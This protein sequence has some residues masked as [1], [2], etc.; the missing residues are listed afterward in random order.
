MQHSVLPTAARNMHAVLL[1]SFGIM[2]AA[3]LLLFAGA[4]DATGTVL[5]HNVTELQAISTDPAGSYLLANDI[6]ASDTVNWAAYP[7]N[8]F[9]PIAS[10]SG[11][12]D[13]GG[14]TI[15]GLYQMSTDDAMFT[16]IATTGNVVNLAFASVNIECSN[17]AAVL[18]NDNKGLIKRCA[19]MSGT[20]SAPTAAGFCV[21][22]NG[23]LVES[24]VN[25]GTDIWG[26]SNA[27]GL[28]ADQYGTVASCSCSGN[29]G[30][31]GLTPPGLVSAGLVFT[32]HSGT[33]QNC[34]VTGTV[35]GAAWAAGFMATAMSG[36][37]VSNCFVAATLSA[38]SKYGFVLT[39]HADGATVAGCC[40]DTTVTGTSTSGAGTGYTT[41]QM[42]GSDSCYSGWDF[43]NVWW[44]PLSG[45][46]CYP[47][48]K[49][50]SWAF[51][52]PYVARAAT[53][54]EWDGGLP[55]TFDVEFHE[56]M[57]GPLADVTD[58]KTGDQTGQVDFGSSTATH[59][60]YTVAGSGSAYTITVTSADGPGTVVANIVPG[61]CYTTSQ[62][63]GFKNLA[64]YS[65]NN[66]VTI[67]A[68]PS[69]TGIALPSDI[70]NHGRADT[71]DFTVTFDLPVTG[72][73]ASDFSV[74]SSTVTGAT[75]TGVSPTSG[76][77]TT[78]TVTVSTGTG[79]GAVQLDLL[80]DDSLITAQNG[81][82]GGW[83]AG[84]GD[85]SGTAALYYLDK[86]TIPATK[87]LNLPGGYTDWSQLDLTHTTWT[88][89]DALHSTGSVLIVD[90]EGPFTVNWVPVSGASFCQDLDTSPT[91][92][93]TAVQ[94]PTGTCS[95][96]RSLGVD[97][98]VTFDHPVTGVDAT[99]FS[100]ANS[101]VS[102][103]SIVSVL[104]DSGYASLFTVR[105]STGTGTGTV[106]LDVVDDNSIVTDLRV[107][108]G[109]FDVADGN[110]SGAAG[111]YYVYK[112]AVPVGTALS[113][114]GGYQWTD[115]DLD[116]TISRPVGAIQQAASGSSTF[117]VRQ[118]GAFTVTWTP[119]SGSPFCQELKSAVGVQSVHRVS[120]SAVDPS[121]F[122][123]PESEVT[124]R[125]TF[126][127]PVTGVDESDFQPTGDGIPSV[128]S[129]AA[130]DTETYNVTLTNLPMRGLVG[131]D[132]LNDGSILDSEGNPLG[133]PFTGTEQ[134]AVD[135]NVYRIGASLP[136]P[137]ELG[138]QRGQLVLA[139]TTSIP[140]KQVYDG[141]SHPELANTVYNTFFVQSA[142][143]ASPAAAAQDAPS[144]L[145][146][147]DNLAP[148]AH[149]KGYTTIA[150][151]YLDGTEKTFGQ[152]IQVSG[153]PAHPAMGVYQTDL[154]SGGQ[155][156]AYKVALGDPLQPSGFTSYIHHNSQVRPP[157][158]Q[159]PAQPGYEV[160]YLWED[161]EKWLHAYKDTGL[162]VLH[163]EDSSLHFL[164]VQVVDVQL[165]Q[166]NATMAM[167][168]GDE[169]T[170]Q[171]PLDAAFKPSAP[172]AYVSAGKNNL[173][174]YVYQ[175]DI[176]GS[177]QGA[178]FAI[179]KT[180]TA[181][182]AEVFWLRYCEGTS[183]GVTDLHIRWPYE[184]T[185][186]TFDWPDETT[187]RGKFQ[188]YVRGKSP[189][190]TGPDVA[191]KTDTDFAVDVMPYY[192]GA[193]GFASYKV[194]KDPSLNN[195][196]ATNG[197]GWSLLRYQTGTPLGSG[198]YFKAVRSAWHDNAAF[199]PN[200][201]T[202]L[203]GNVGVEITDS[204]NHKPGQ[205]YNTYAQNSGQWQETPGTP[206][207][208]FV[209]SNS[210]ENRYDWKIYDGNDGVDAVTVNPAATGQ[211]IPVNTGDLEVWWYQHDTQADSPSPR[212]G[213]DWPMLPERYAVA[214]PAATNE[215]VIARQDGTGVIPY[216]T[217]EL[218]YQND[219]TRPG[220]NPND[221]HAL[222]ETYGS[223]MAVF[224]L[225]CDLGSGATSL[226]YVLIRHRDA[227][228]NSLWNYDVYSVRAEKTVTSGVE[229]YTFQDW[230]QKGLSAT[231]S[232]SD[233]Y[234]KWAGTVMQPPWPLAAM[235]LCDETTCASGPG[236][237]DRESTYWAKA[238]GDAGGTA[239]VA[240]QF[241]YVNQPDFYWPTGPTPAV[242]AHV[243]WLDGYH[244]VPGTP[245]TVTY[246][247]HWPDDATIPTMKTGDIL[248]KAR[249]GL[250]AM[251]GNVSVR[252]LYQQSTALNP[253]KSSTEVIDFERKRPVPPAAPVIL[254]A[255]PSD[256][257][258][259]EKQGLTYFPKLDPALKPR[260][261]YN[262][263]NSELGFTGFFVEP[264]LGDYYAFLDVM[265]DADKKELL[266][267]SNNTA[268]TTAVNALYAA[269][270]TVVQV[271][272]DATDFE[273]DGLALTTGFATDG[274][275]VTLAFNNAV[276]ARPGP[277]SL[278]IIKVVKDWKP[279]EIAEIP[280]DCP[281]DERLVMMHKGDF[282]G[283]PDQYKF[284]WRTHPDVDG[285]KP[286]WDPNTR[287]VTDADKYNTFTPD[288]T[289]YP[290][291]VGAHEITIEG[292]GLF[293]LSD[294]WFICR[295]T[296]K[297]SGAKSW[298]DDWSDWTEPQLAPG[299]IKRVVGEISPFTQRASGGGI[300]GAET[301]F[302]SFSDNAVN[303]VVSM[304]SQAGPRWDGDVPLNCQNLD[305]F[306]LIQIYETVFG[307][308]RAL[309]VDAGYDYAPANNA[310]LLVAGRCADLYMLL[311]NE[312]YAD[313]ADPT[314]AYGTN[315]AW[316]YASQATSIHCFMNQTGSLMEEELALLRGRDDSQSPPVSTQPVYNRLIW[317]F[318]TDMNGGEVA[319]ALNYN[320]QD[321]SGNADG[322]I[323]ENDAKKL[324]PQGHGDAWG[325]YLSAIKR[326]YKL[327]RHPNYTWVPR[328]EAVMV[329]GVAVTV[330]F[331]DERKFAKAAAARARTGAEIMNLTYRQYYTEDPAGQWQG[332]HDSNTDRAWGVSE[333]GCR[334]GTGAYFDWV[335]GNA[336]LP[337]DDTDPT[338]TGIRKIDR[339]TVADL[340]DIAAAYDQIE[341][342]MKSADSGLN[343]L[344]LAK[345]VTPFDI[346]PTAIDAGETHFEQIYARAMTALTN[347]VSVFNN[348]ANC[349]Q[350]L[351]RQSDTL[352]Q[353]QQTVTDQEADFNNRLIE[354]FGYPYAEDIGPTGTYPT[355]YNGPD[356]YHYDIVDDN[357]LRQDITQDTQAFTVKL[358]ESYVDG[359][360]QVRNPAQVG[361]AFLTTED[362]SHVHEVTFQLSLSNFGIVKPSGWTSRRAPGE[363]QQTRSDLLQGAGNFKKCIREYQDTVGQI[364]DQLTLITDKSA[365]FGAEMFVRTGK[366]ATDT[367]I[368]AYILGLNAV[369]RGLQ[370]TADI[371]DK[372]AD[373]ETE[374]IPKVM[375]LVAGVACGT[376]TDAL[377][378]LRGATQ[379]GA[380]GLEAGALIG[381]DSA[382][383]SAE[384]AQATKDA[385][386][387]GFDLALEGLSG[388]EEIKEETNKLVA[389]GR[390]ESIKREELY[391]LA[392]ALDQA[393]GAY[394]AALASG[395][396]ILS[397]RLRFRQQ[398]AA[399]VQSFRYQDMAFR[400]FRNDALQKYQAQFDLASRYTYLAAKAYDYETNLLG[401]AGMAGEQFL[402]KVVKCRA[403]GIIDANGVPQTGGT[404]DG[405]DPGLASIMAEMEQNFSLVLRGQL[406]FNN[407]Q[408]ETNRFSLRFGLFR[409]ANDDSI[410]TDDAKWRAKLRSLVVD[411]ILTLPEFRQYCSEFNPH[412]ATEPGIVIKFPSE[413]TFGKNFF[414]WPA[415]GGD[416][417]YSSTHFATKIRS[418]GVWFGNYDSLA[419]S[420]GLTET[421]RVYLFPAGEDRMRSPNDGSLVRG[422]HVLDQKLPVP[423]PVSSGNLSNPDYIPQ[424]D[425]FGETFAAL[426]K[427]PDFRAYHDSGSDW[428]S[429]LDG[430]SRLVGRSVWNTEWVLIIPA[431]Y[432][433]SNR[434]KA[435][436]VFI[437]GPDGEGGVS[438]I[439]LF[440]QT[441]AY[442]S[443]SK[444]RDGAAAVVV[445]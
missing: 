211:I 251:R 412:Q 105:V 24:F 413:V 405:S 32:H 173:S 174:G 305:S 352:A 196:F 380:I 429:E 311:G 256:I 79:E 347:A 198:L 224:P 284:E 330:D 397:D 181:A 313:A 126:T 231:S 45:S 232:D 207:Y 286:Y 393:K 292:P 199:F 430:D 33:I 116:A 239:N 334:A 258:T 50:S 80:D 179:Q 87:P 188:L 268:W 314:I 159:D 443:G 270:G 333:W 428:P 101:T 151:H 364:K 386:D 104:P 421:P 137:L 221:E 410:L 55:L 394:R 312:A 240:M 4:A 8:G 250:P 331:M 341:D 106:Q 172:F 349:T 168:L 336:I 206:G 269:S 191:L 358:S 409:T 360:G 167:D 94:I 10:F 306:G 190:P 18:C 85:L 415:V 219:K 42:Q 183:Q 319:Y 307:R 371:A 156:A 411:D 265:T 102:G 86:R 96:T 142:A 44:H 70:C 127:D 202:P 316:Q 54:A 97:F 392:A 143:P 337:P 407:P 283:Q 223:G 320:I 344:G 342:R 403:L 119:L 259:E 148:N 432:L 140:S 78:Y 208:V 158:D 433:Q 120:P 49:Y 91:P 43:T 98:N 389:L 402:T 400:I 375:G 67:P 357:A 339:K 227:N 177:K 157:E 441:Y 234:E 3:I 12:L 373:A 417:A 425:S 254:A 31:A 201:T 82:L 35:T 309:S 125:V 36:S 178:V 388:G 60:K 279:G 288:T 132:V 30:H 281:F 404:D 390:Q 189:D 374:S 396:R 329:G 266:A 439:L 418:T 145:F 109:G 163:F 419:G 294:N 255:I 310:L 9:V 68:Y 75:I 326:Y 146:V 170:S 155:T 353:F 408:T 194:T 325:H 180:S 40:W 318:T 135:R 84:N 324:Y 29:V 186:Y 169:L 340:H 22:N 395:A 431:G 383:T 267:L 21:T 299:W 100:V 37:T 424:N 327:L 423:F 335:E 237:R 247:I 304:I 296:K 355:G 246:T 149:P 213:N 300:E 176:A 437:D 368:G 210:G 212:A 248:V 420:G 226:P 34:Y 376:I 282:D 141:G 118:N 134:F 187:E 361:D 200:R 370:R 139:D 2:T 216:S 17:S 384:V 195:A 27:A 111:L 5:I 184:M 110:F 92:H 165:C 133:A 238:A 121:I 422:W 345:D 261:V 228:A 108:L 278:E 26:T 73:D 287:R 89:P 444:S 71:V 436:D 242:G 303:T 144:G 150:W 147:G 323:D 58:F 276:A 69:A 343:P 41:S 302:S 154:N 204:A 131:M 171:A 47:F 122:H 72:V 48:L 88:P 95:H 379:A 192:A 257:A 77:T 351:R 273:P 209:A 241:Y 230:P 38:T 152:E 214:W 435:L 381:R 114:P 113:P 363:I 185:H 166:A 103:A 15:T 115:L 218:Y 399:Q 295:Y 83:G 128:Y 301:T 138:F 438:D 56:Y 356:L 382:I 123:T 205:P 290:G 99:D 93:V 130:V 275:Y 6:D 362:R 28:V 244:S 322:V 215:I 369:A 220:F 90:K 16:T 328:A 61:V 297:S 426:R 264:A 25:P 272:D 365:F 175:H 416:S 243:P 233:P 1:L 377:A 225:R 229:E 434:Q 398:T 23:S 385:L 203:N 20:V 7:Y 52:V 64:N 346:D 414:G 442:A 124:F 387:E 440:F 401:T 391:T 315:D 367:G 338:H 252:T 59:I 19:I 13:G 332:Y 262:P 129:V 161:A 117:T 53:Q 76:Y 65:V 321:Q 406:G 81:H 217:W 66:V 277:V 271:P 51:A 350:L 372:A 285:S 249:Y 263:T 298:P 107:P 14:H 245:T 162:V 57:F 136:L 182:K 153:E 63:S 427:F 317:N 39:G 354:S 378:P 348:A 222:V 445:K 280:P 291:G 253:A 193:D 197:P 260:V 293:T 164:G 74:A 46:P 235:P 359:N 308:G 11:T 160:Q 62:Y 289:L 366:L 236:W 112:A 274:G